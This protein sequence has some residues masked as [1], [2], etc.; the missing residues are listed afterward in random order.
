MYAN[1]FCGFPFFAV[2]PLLL[3]QSLYIHF[4]FHHLTNL[5]KSLLFSLPHINDACSFVVILNKTNLC[6]DSTRTFNNLRQTTEMRSVQLSTP[7]ITDC[8]WDSIF[9]IKLIQIAISCDHRQPK[10]SVNDQ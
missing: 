6:H 8:N 9:F 3:L 5:R 7:A 2:L 4:I 10:C 1:A